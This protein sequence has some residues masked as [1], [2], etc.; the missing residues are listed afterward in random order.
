MDRTGAI[1]RKGP[2]QHLHRRE[3]ELRRESAEDTSIG[4][5]RRNGYDQLR[6]ARLRIPVCIA[7]D[8]IVRFQGRLPVRR[9]RDLG[10]LARTGRDD[11]PIE[12]EHHEL[13]EV[14]LLYTSPS[15]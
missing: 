9:E 11:V 10:H 14:C 12:V 5:L 7:D 4:A 8:L 2:Q 1:R 13:L 15:P 3:I 6:S